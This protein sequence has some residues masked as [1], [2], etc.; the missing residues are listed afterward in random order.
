MRSLAARWRRAAPTIAATMQPAQ[1]AGGHQGQALVAMVPVP[2]QAVQCGSGTAAPRPQIEHRG[3][4]TRQ[5]GWRAVSG[6]LARTGSAQIR[7]GWGAVGRGVRGVRGLADERSNFRPSP[8][9][10]RPPRAHV[11]FMLLLLLLDVAGIRE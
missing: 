6:L 5:S 7:Q 11:F 3:A 4:S 8:A 1:G 9:P 10:A 2:A